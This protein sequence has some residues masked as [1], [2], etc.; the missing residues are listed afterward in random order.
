M[1]SHFFI[2]KIIIKKLRKG[3]DK[4]VKI[5]YSNRAPQKGG[6]TL[7]IKQRKLE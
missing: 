7:K 6:R 5:W 2:M 3:I 4:G 1:H